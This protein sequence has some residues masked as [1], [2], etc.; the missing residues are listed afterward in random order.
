[1]YQ[2]YFPIEYYIYS[3]KSTFNFDFKY[4]K[5]PNSILEATSGYT[6]GNLLLSS[7]DRNSK[8]NF[9]FPL[10]I[11]LIELSTQNRVYSTPKIQNGITYN[12]FERLIPGVYIVR[13]VDDI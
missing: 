9:Y 8:F 7:T 13:N 3:F 5:D 12:F 10:E 1:M 6:G 11:Y 4:Q 2:N